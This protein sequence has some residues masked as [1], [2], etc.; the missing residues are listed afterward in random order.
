V[1]QMKKALRIFLI[2]FSPASADNQNVCDFDPLNFK[3]E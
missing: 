2:M 1:G 3:L